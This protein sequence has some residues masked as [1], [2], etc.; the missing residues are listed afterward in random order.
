MRRKLILGLTLFIGGFLLTEVSHIMDIWI[1]GVIGRALW[2]IGMV[3]SINVLKE[4]G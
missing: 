2:P 3:I 4:D 1:G